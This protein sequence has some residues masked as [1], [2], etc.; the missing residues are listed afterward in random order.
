[1]KP[2]VIKI[3]PQNIDVDLIEQA[4]EVIHNRGLVAFPTET[5]YGLGANALDPEAV[6]GIFEAKK[7]PLDDPLIVHIVDMNELNALS[8]DV[9][10]APFLAGAPYRGSE[11]N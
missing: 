10:P 9:P 3:D 2:R 4:S 11:E 6:T 1:M 5:V 7:R 8:K